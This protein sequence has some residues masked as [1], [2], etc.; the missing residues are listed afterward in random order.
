MIV[1]VF[2][3]AAAK[4]KGIWLFT[5]VALILVGIGYQLSDRIPSQF[6]NEL[7]RKETILVRMEFY[8]IALEVIREKP[9]FGLGFNSPLSRF[10]P[11]D[12]EPK[13]YPVGGGGDNSFTSMVS[14]VHVFDNM[15]L[16][17]LGETGGFF[18]MAYIGLGLYLILNILIF[19]KHHAENHVKTLLIIAVLAG[20]AVHSLTFDSLKSPNLNWIFHSLLALFARNHVI[21]N[22]C[23]TLTKHHSEV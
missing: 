23:N 19:R 14:G 1:I 7:L 12:Y 13:I 21:D 17:F 22:G 10:I 9:I 18:T 15:A 11:S 3:I 2:F 5:L 16:C 4:R 8:H 20:F 6:K